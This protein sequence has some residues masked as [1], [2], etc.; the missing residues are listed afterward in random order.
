MTWK[1]AYRLILAALL[2]ALTV[3]LS[4]AA[5]RIWR[6]GTARK[7]ENPLE[8]VYTPEKVA[9]VL[10]RI[11]PL[12]M[13]TA[14]MAA[15]GLALGIRDEKSPRPVSS[16]EAERNL[17]VSRLEQPGKE[18]RKERK[19]QRT[20]RWISWTAFALCM[21][22]ILLYCADRGHFPENDL[23]GMIAALA[24]HTFPWAAAGLLCLLTGTL[25]EEKSMR[26][27]AGAAR[28]QLKAEKGAHREPAAAGEP[29]GRG[30]GAVR[31][32]LLLAAGVLIVLGVLNGSLNDVLMKA[33]NICTECIG[34]G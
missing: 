17:L 30:T 3:L 8:A 24:L 21:V 7:V 19:R 23:E 27:E 18:I 26:R 5:V 20:I 2:V 29:A 15:A 11:S 9:E 14:V 13:V 4:A 16:P 22:P 31:T 10:L 33:I 28:A 1:K 34:L 32:L 6:E 25:L 12:L